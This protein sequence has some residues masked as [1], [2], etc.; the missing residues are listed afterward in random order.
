MPSL[1]PPPYPGLEEGNDATL[2]DNTVIPPK[3]AETRPNQPTQQ[4]APA[5][6]P[7]MEMGTLPSVPSTG[8]T[9]T[10]MV[11]NTPL[12]YATAPNTPLPSQNQFAVP[13]Y[14]AQQAQPLGAPLNGGM[15]APGMP[16]QGVPTQGIPVPGAP[17]PGM[18]PC[19]GS[20]PSMPMGYGAAGVLPGM[21]P[22][23]PKCRLGYITRGQARVREMCI[24]ALAYAT[25]CC[26]CFL[27]LQLLKT[28]YVDKCTYCG[29]E[30]GFRGELFEKPKP[31]KT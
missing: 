16:T 29:E 23:C 26:T 7:A 2:K 13:P 12:P 17:A 11:P 18:A 19:V 21:A 5:A 28:N 9:N 20:P 6:G 8:S 10:N 15:A 14:A 22:P 3:A 27:P 4:K 25:V 31:P 1:D 30:Y 24:K